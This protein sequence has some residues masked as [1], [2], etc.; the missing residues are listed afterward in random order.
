MTMVE[1]AVT[2]GSLPS[3]LLA[4]IF[5]SGTTLSSTSPGCLPCLVV[6]SAVSQRWRSAAL[7]YP[8]LWTKIHVPFSMRNV[9]EWTA[10]CLERSKSCLFDI[11]LRLPEPVDMDIVTRVMLLVVQHVQRLRLLA[12][13][14]EAEFFPRHPEEIFALLLNA[15]RVPCLTMLELTFSDPHP[16]SMTIP[17][18]GLLV[19]APSLSFLRLHGVVSPVPFVGLRYLEIQGLRA[20][21]T[22]FRDMVVASPLLTN[23]ILPKLRLMVDLKSKSL[24]SIEIPTLKTLAVSFTKPPPSNSFNPCHNLLSLL[25]IPNLE[26]LELAGGSMPDLARCFQPPGTFTRLCTLRLVNASIF[27]RASQTEE[28]IDN[29]DYLRALTTV[30]ELQLIHSYAEYLLPTERSPEQRPRGFPRTR[31]INLRDRMLGPARHPHHLRPEPLL[32]E[33]RLPRNRL[34]LATGQP[35]APESVAIYPNLRSVS[36]D[37]LPAGE[38]LWLYRLVLQRPQIKVVK[39]S[40]VTER[41]LATSLGTIDGVLQILPNIHTN[42]PGTAEREPVDVGKLLREK[43]TVQQIEKD[44]YI[45]WR[46]AV[47]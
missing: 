13:T 17:Q 32:H 26:Y 16:V 35:Q 44:G 9:V 27:A 41:H 29:C 3:E 10:L 2:I 19:Q 47:I 5:E 42:K 21:Y 12:I 1:E 40:P 4:Q 8:D 31:S 30:E 33:A 23:L 34:N 25:F 11:T 45:Q 36:L 38:V 14:A 7:D 24:P 46:G 43:V 28:A 6:Y 37:T 39:L 22:D 18:G 20:A 15:Q